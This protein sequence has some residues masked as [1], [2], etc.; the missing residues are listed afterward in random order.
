VHAK[1]VSFCVSFHA[2][3]GRMAQGKNKSK[4][5]A[6]G[7]AQRGGGGEM[8][9]AGAT[10]GPRAAL[11]PPNQCP[12][13]CRA[14]QGQ[15]GRQEEDVSAARHGVMLHDSPARA[16]GGAP[17]APGILPLTYGPPLPCHAVSTPSPRR[18]GARTAPAAAAGS[19]KQPWIAGAAGGAARRAAM[20]APGPRLHVAAGRL[21]PPPPR[22]QAAAGLGCLCLL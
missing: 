6:Q 17:P 19:G 10:G 11:T 3:S 7:N 8:A 22:R 21:P 13:C 15:E 5:M 1:S 2:E 4:Q 14:V 18:T 12:C 20:A 16:P 9:M